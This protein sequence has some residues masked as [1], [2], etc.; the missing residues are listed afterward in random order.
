MN[1]T[2]TPLP[3]GIALP[4]ENVS[5]CTRTPLRIVGYAGFFFSRTWCPF[6]P[7]FS[8]CFPFF[9]FLSVAKKLQDLLQCCYVFA[10]FTNLTGIRHVLDSR[11]RASNT[12]IVK[13]EGN[14]MTPN[15]LLKQDALQH[16]GAMQ[17]NRS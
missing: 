9:S 12:D 2:K 7:Y 5:T 16:H 4:D 1:L 3:S 8:L 6:L 13:D 11:H 15:L 17:A 10:H 14:K